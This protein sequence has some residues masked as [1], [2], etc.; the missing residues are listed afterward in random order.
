IFLGAGVGLV[1]GLAVL[2]FVMRD[3]WLGSGGPKP[4]D[5]Y[6][7][8]HQ[9]FLLDNDDDFKSAAHDLLQAHAADETNAL[10]SAE[11]AEIYT[12]WAFY[13]RE[14][15]LALDGGGAQAEA[16]ARRLRKD[17]QGRL[18]DAK[19]FAGDALARAP[20]SAEANRAMADYQRVDNAPAAEVERY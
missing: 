12:T 1:V 5:A 4:N 6:A 16:V 11:L 7:K 18:D 2:L 14:D 8:A 19:R 17:A 10:L 13:L 3:R 9:Q 20:D 15:A